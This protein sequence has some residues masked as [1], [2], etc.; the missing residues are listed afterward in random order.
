MEM[1]T[2]SQTARDKLGRQNG[3]SPDPVSYTHLDVYKRQ[4]LYVTIRRL[5]APILEL[6]RLS[7]EMSHMNF[8]VQYREPRHS[9]QELRILGR[10][11]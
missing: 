7:E 5:T 4:L 9:M 11:V 8:E 10:C 2:G 1:M 6:A 3:K